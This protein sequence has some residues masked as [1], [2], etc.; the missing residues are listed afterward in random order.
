MRKYVF[1]IALLCFTQINIVAQVSI[2]LTFENTQDALFF[3]K[4]NP[5]FQKTA[6][7][8]TTGIQILR[9]VLRQL[10]AQTYLE[11][12]F[13]SIQVSKPNIAAKLHLTRRRRELTRATS[14][15]GSKG[16]TR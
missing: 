5:N 9:G 2:Q 8:T 16:L 11:A 1:F 4:T 6:A 12:A 3:L 13:D 14:S 10:H 7:D 15:S